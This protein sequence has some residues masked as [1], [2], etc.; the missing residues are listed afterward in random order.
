MKGIASK[1]ITDIISSLGFSRVSFG[2]VRWLTQNDAGMSRSGVGAIWIY[3]ATT[4]KLTTQ[5]A[6]KI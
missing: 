3:K 6:L 5:K 4:E 1:E 2:L